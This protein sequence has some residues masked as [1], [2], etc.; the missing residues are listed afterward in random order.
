MIDWIMASSALTIVI[1]AVGKFFGDRLTPGV[2]YDLWFWSAFSTAVTVRQ[3]RKGELT[4][5]AE[6]EVFQR[7]VE[8][9]C[10]ELQQAKE[11]HEAEYVI[12]AHEIV[13][14][15]EYFLLRYSPRDVALYT[16]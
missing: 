1:F 10:T 6:N 3:S 2:Q 12:Q 4:A 13:H 16:G 9:L 5:S 14:D 15:M 7:D 11:T 8:A